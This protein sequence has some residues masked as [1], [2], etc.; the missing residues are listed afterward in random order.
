LGDIYACWER[1]GDARIR[2]GRVPK[3]GD[4]ILN[5]T[6]Q[7]KWRSRTVA[8]NPVCR[9]C[10]YALHC[11]GGC[12]VL[13]EAQNGGFFTNHCDGYAQRFRAAV[14]GAYLEHHQGVPLEE[15]APRICDQ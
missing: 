8:T 9:G 12:A 10:R 7:L 4:I 3:Q 5:P 13:A 11:G 1:T 6:V 15:A 14:A 2:I